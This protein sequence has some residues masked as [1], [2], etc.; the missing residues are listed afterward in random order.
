MKDAC[1]SIADN[2]P[3][4]ARRLRLIL[5][6]T[7]VLLGVGLVSPII[8]LKKFVLI[9]NTFSVLGGVIELLKEGQVFLF[10]VITGFSIVI[11]LLKIGILNKLL[12]AKAKKTKNLDK[13][14]HWMHLYGKWSMLDVF[15]VAVLVVAVKLGAIA[16]VEMRYG[17]YAF[18]AAVVLTMYVTA[19]VVSLTNGSNDNHE[20]PGD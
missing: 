7:T 6:V 1:T 14:L 15:V 8:T 3:N 16:S 4:A 18:A 20:E 5:A 19:R 13:Y 2:H 11:P 12:G 17:L 10:I 9:E